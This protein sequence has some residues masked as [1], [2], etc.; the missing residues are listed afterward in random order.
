[1]AVVVELTHNIMTSV[2]PGYQVG[3]EGVGNGAQ[4]FLLSPVF[5]GFKHHL[6]CVSLDGETG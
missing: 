6:E 4:L 3:R 1:M 2:A 5:Q